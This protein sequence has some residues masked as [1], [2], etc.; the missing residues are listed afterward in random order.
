[1]LPLLNLKFGQYFNRH[2]FKLNSEGKKRLAAKLISTDYF[3]FQFFLMVFICMQNSNIKFPVYHM[4]LLFQRLS[5]ITSRFLFIKIKM[6]K[7]NSF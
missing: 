2:Y 6:G 7:A 4:L 1:M 5:L 3:N